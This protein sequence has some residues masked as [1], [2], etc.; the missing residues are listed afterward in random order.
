M[1]AAQL[2]FYT[3]V[4]LAS[5]HVEVAAHAPG[6]SVGIP[7]NPV[8][9]L[10]VL[11]IAPAHQENCVVELLLCHFCTWLSEILISLLFSSIDITRLHIL[12]IITIWCKCIILNHRNLPLGLLCPHCFCHVGLISIYSLLAYIGLVRCIH[13]D[14]SCKICLGTWGSICLGRWVQLLALGWSLLSINLTCWYFLWNWRGLNHDSWL[15]HLE[16]VIAFEFSGHGTVHKHLFS[17]L[18]ICWREVVT[19]DVVTLRNFCI[20]LTVLVTWAT[21]SLCSSCVRCALLSHESS[22]FC[23]KTVEDGPASIAAFIHIVALHHELRRELWLVAEVAVLQLHPRLNGLDEAHSVAWATFSLISQRTGEIIA[24]NIPEVVVVGYFMIWDMVW[25][26][27]CLHPVLCPLD[28]LFELIT[29]LAEFAF[30]RQWILGEVCKLM[31][32]LLSCLIVS[33][34][35]LI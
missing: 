22:I 13:L 11:V 8:G 27:I 16:I 32:W 12:T 14:T 2:W 7:H 24:A 21:S 18:H 28:R 4:V 26:L 15:V 1:V 6:I 9:H 10:F 3:E 19:I 33:T 5:A 20:W 25:R 31:L 34:F 17:N 30:S 29:F 23:K 35:I